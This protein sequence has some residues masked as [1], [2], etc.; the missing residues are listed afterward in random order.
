ML[1]AS[2]GR[3]RHR[4]DSSPGITHSFTNF[5]QPGSPQP[6][7]TLTRAGATKYQVEHNWL[8]LRPTLFQFQPTTVIWP[9]LDDDTQNRRTKVHRF[10]V[11]P[12][13]DS[14]YHDMV[15]PLHEET[16]T[17]PSMMTM[18]NKCDDRRARNSAARNKK[19]RRFPRK[20]HPI[21]SIRH[22]S[23]PSIIRAQTLSSI[24]AWRTTPR[25]PRN[26]RQDEKQ[27]IKHP[28]APPQTPRKMQCNVSPCLFC[29]GS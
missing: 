11:G 3:A 20:Y 1:P 9:A 16:S 4:Q 28:H 5:W 25:G 19:R 27:K 12:E 17:I 29:L 6:W 10:Q 24:T 23:G 7:L 14:P 18:A 13:S 21:P 22:R 8:R 2:L 26:P 15:R